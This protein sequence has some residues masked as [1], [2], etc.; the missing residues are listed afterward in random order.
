MKADRSKH[1]IVSTAVPEAA[2]HNALIWV[3][4]EAGSNPK[5]AAV[6]P[7]A[8]ASGAFCGSLDE[9]CVMAHRLWSDLAEDKGL[10]PIAMVPAS[11]LA[12]FGPHSVILRNQ[13]SSSGL[14]WLCP[15]ATVGAVAGAAFDHICPPD[16][17]AE[18]NRDYFAFLLHDDLEI[19]SHTRHPRR[20]SVD[21]FGCDGALFWLEGI[22]LPFECGDEIS[23]LAIIL[24]SRSNR[25]TSAENIF[26]LDES[27]ILQVP[28][29]PISVPVAERKLTKKESLRHQEG[30]S[31]L[32]VVQKASVA[33]LIADARSAACEAREAEDRSRMALYAA[34]ERSYDI[35]RR[36]AVAP[37]EFA[38]QIVFGADC[39][40][41]Q[42]AEYV[43]V[44]DRA[45]ERNIP[46][47]ELTI[48]L[49]EQDNGLAANPQTSRWTVHASC[50]ADAAE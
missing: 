21:T 12:A 44:L 29:D 40:E 17:I 22:L 3:A 43:A 39:S 38:A 46:V 6:Q 26:D 2:E 19:V 28:P 50:G 8:Q 31:M 24:E 7:M 13:E 27:A 48:F 20:F 23:V 25:G 36:A 42:L 49:C 9:M 15:Q 30:M 41:S 18:T 14:A 37:E 47:G 10:P 35:A 16:G 45:R 1:F 5:E 4:T 34:L 32:H 33:D 11:H